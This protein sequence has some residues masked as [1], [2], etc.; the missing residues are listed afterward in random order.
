VTGLLKKLADNPATFASRRFD[1]Q[2]AAVCYRRDP[3]TAELQVL[4]VTSR[5]TGR[6]VL[7]KG[8]PM[9]GKKPHRAAEIEAWEEAGVRGKVSKKSLGTFTYLKGLKDGSV[10]P[11]TVTLFPLEVEDLADCYD[12]KSQR[13]RRW[14]DCQDAAR[15]VQEPE[16][17]ILL[18]TLDN[19]LSPKDKKRHA[20]HG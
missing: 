4:L 2:Y 8:W 14:A 18:S 3:E 6:W 16:L 17:K 15:S 5:D 13:A 10:V 9:K 20:K 1:E 7:P 11:C 12:E 19:R